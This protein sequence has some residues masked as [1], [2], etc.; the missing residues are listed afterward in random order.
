MFFIYFKKYEIVILASDLPEY[1]KLLE[2]HINK[3]QMHTMNC[4]ASL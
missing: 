2:I 4:D 1:F 3:R